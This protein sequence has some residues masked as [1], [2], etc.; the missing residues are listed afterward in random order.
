MHCP[1]ADIEKCTGDYPEAK[2]KNC[3]TFQALIDSYPA[4]DK[5]LRKSKKAIDE[6]I[7]DLF[8]VTSEEDIQIMLDEF[9]VLL[10]CKTAGVDADKMIS[11][12]R[13]VF[14]QN[15]K[16]LIK[17]MPKRERYRLRYLLELRQYTSDYSGSSEPMNIRVENGIDQMKKYIHNA[18]C[19]TISSYLSK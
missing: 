7:G 11:D 5:I 8:S 9:F 1:L 17:D 16:S 14:A 18:I 13:D 3:P 19:E 10:I 2:C 4:T 12:D 6:I 15:I